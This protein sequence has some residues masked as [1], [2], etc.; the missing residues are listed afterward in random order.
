[1][2]IESKPSSSPLTIDKYGPEAYEAYARIEAE[3]PVSQ[4]LLR[5]SEILPK[6]TETSST[7][8]FKS[9]D[10]L[11]FSTAP[12]VSWGL[13]EAPKGFEGNTR[14]NFSAHFI[15]SISPDFIESFLDNFE[16]LSQP[17][18]IAINPILDLFVHVG[19]LARIGEQIY[20]QR[21]SLIRT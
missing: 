4:E 16:K 1:M 5:Y 10:S 15:E 20:Y 18:K 6:I 19:V 14:K 2:S 21:L 11:F 7:K 8:P 3:A 9:S 17:E 13:A 12:T